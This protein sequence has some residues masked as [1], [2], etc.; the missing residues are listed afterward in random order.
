[1]PLS[2]FHT[3]NL[4]SLIKFKFP[5]GNNNFFFVQK[6]DLRLKNV[7]VKTN[8]LIDFSRFRWLLGTC[9]PSLTPCAFQISATSPMT[10]DRPT[11]TECVANSYIFAFAVIFEEKRLLKRKS[12]ES[13]FDELSDGIEQSDLAGDTMPDMSNLIFMV[14]KGPVQA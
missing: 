10:P 8:A 9:L 7:V 2:V 1:M 13:S 3:R 4:G 12:D 6:C 5:L 11:D 14:E